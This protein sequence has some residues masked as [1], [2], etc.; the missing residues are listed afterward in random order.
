MNE[1]A[2]KWF[3]RAA[4]DLEREVGSDKLAGAARR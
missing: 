1:W 3:E 4:E 2:A